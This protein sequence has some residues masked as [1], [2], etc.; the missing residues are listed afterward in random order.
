MIRKRVTELA[1]EYGR[2]GYKRITGLMRAEGFVV[3]KKRV[4][5]IWREEGLKVPARQPKKARLWLADGSCIRKKAEY[6]NHVWTYDFVSD[7]TSDGR[8]FRILNIVDEF[9][10][11]CLIS[12]VA[13]T[14]KAQDVIFILA[15]LFLK[16]GCPVHIRSDNGPEFVAK[17]LMNWFKLLEIKPLFIE[18]GSPWE[19][20][21]IESF[22]ARMRDEFLNGEIFYTLL[23]AK[24]LI[25]RWVHHYNTKRPHSSLNYKPPA[26]EAIQ[27][28][29]FSLAV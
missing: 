14:I 18:P 25:E 24:I 5:R 8:K 22:N 4:E 29:M 13:R 20:G 16:H 10:R 15:D 28:R 19:N 6:K 9:S 11:E 21:F 7:K 26:P 2:Y 17:A 12:F 27:P 3:N 23:E 1:K